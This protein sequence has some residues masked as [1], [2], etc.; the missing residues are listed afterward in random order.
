MLDGQEGML[1]G[2]EGLLGSVN[3]EFD[4]AFWRMWRVLGPPGWSI[5]GGLLCHRETPEWTVK[6]GKG[7]CCG[8]LDCERKAMDESEDVNGFCVASSNS[9]VS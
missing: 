4:I 6:V 9:T 1:D 5:A 7:M 8:E 3:E 2:L